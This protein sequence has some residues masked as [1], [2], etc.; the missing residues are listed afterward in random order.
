MGL[1]VS[2]ES[3]LKIIHLDGGNYFLLMKAVHSFALFKY[4]IDIKLKYDSSQWGPGN[5]IVH[6]IKS[7]VAIKNQSSSFQS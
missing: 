3:C 1:K 5:R 2:F 4:T 7:T 6:V